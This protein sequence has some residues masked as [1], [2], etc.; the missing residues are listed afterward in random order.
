MEFEKLDIFYKY[1]VNRV[2]YDMFIGMM[3]EIYPG[4]TSYVKNKWEEYIRNPVG[5]IISRHERKLF[6]A[7]QQEM[8]RVD[9]KG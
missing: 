5:F 7:I 4:S 3:L 9:Y 8:K 1:C 2:T 6:E